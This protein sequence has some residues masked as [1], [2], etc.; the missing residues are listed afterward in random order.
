MSD[1]VKGLVR[2]HAEEH[3]IN[4]TCAVPSLHSSSE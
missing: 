1:D 3:L 2:T 4:V